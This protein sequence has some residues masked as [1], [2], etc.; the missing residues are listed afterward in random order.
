MRSMS[1][2][3]TGAGFRA[4]LKRQGEPLSPRETSQLDDPDNLREKRVDLH[5]PR[6]PRSP[7]RPVTCIGGGDTGMEIRVKGQESLLQEHPQHVKEDHVHLPKNHAAE[8]AH[9]GDI[10]STSDQLKVP[11]TFPDLIPSCHVGQSIA[12]F[13]TSQELVV[14]DKRITVAAEAVPAEKNAGE[15]AFFLT[16][17]YIL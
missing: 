13:T 9:M 14:E 5:L 10:C 3:I 2:D 1:H 4:Q 15:E 6:L 8:K 12:R 7:C 11:S 17:F 16:I